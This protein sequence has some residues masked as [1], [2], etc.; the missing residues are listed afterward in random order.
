MKSIK[1]TFK[2]RYFRKVITY[3]LTW[4][5]V[6]NTSLPGALAEVVLQ[7][8]GIQNGTITVTPLE[9]GITQNMKVSNDAIG[10]FSDFDIAEGHTVTC[11]QN[12]ANSNALFRVFSGDGTQILGQFDANGNIFLVDPAG[13]LFGVNSKVNVNRL[14]A[15]SLDISNEDFLDGKY[16]FSAGQDNTGTIV[17]NGTIGDKGNR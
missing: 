12:S 4:C 3:F 5:L 16:E 13:I 1:K 14:V 10:N 8:D 17:N 11:V 6:L 9:E 2:R 7:T 15:S